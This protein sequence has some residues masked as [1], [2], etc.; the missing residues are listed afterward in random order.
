MELEPQKSRF[1]REDGKRKNSKIPD[2]PEGMTDRYKKKNEF[3]SSPLKIFISTEVL[4][5]LAG[6]IL[7]ALAY[8]TFVR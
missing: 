4:L 7:A 8:W 6:L 5:L 2:I 1:K 3:G